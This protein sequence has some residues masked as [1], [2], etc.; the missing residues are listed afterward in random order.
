MTE[1]IYPPF[2]TINDRCHLV[3]PVACQEVL[4]HVRGQNVLQQHAVQVLHGLD[5]LTLTLELVPPQE[6]Q[7]TVVFILL[8]GNR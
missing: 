6:V 7:P 4:G 2:R 3:L 1:E 5:L 8:P